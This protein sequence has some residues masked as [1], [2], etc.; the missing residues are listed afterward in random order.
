MSSCVDVVHP[1]R[2]LTSRCVHRALPGLILQPACLSTVFALQ[3]ASEVFVSLSCKV[4]HDWPESSR[5]TLLFILVVTSSP[6]MSVS[7]D[8]LLSVHV[9]SAKLFLKSAFITFLRGLHD[10]LLC[11]SGPPFAFLELFYFLEENA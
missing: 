9:H 2:L 4:T 6:L 8:E 7:Y 3:R 5:L 11:I 1:F 10:F